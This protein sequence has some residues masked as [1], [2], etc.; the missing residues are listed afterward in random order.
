MNCCDFRARPNAGDRQCIMNSP[1]SLGDG[2]LRILDLRNRRRFAR[3]PFS[4]NRLVCAHDTQQVAASDCVQF[5]IGPAA[6]GLFNQ[7]GR[8]LVVAIKP[9]GRARDTIEIGAESDSATG[10]PRAARSQY[11]LPGSMQ[12]QHCQE[13]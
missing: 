3:L 13:A 4:H 7:Q 8:I 5:T 9:I 1:T 10:R 2:L 11:Q 6:T 12:D